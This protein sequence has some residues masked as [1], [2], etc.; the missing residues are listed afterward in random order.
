[1]WD[2]KQDSYNT[3]NAFPSSYQSN[4]QVWSMW[5]QAVFAN[6]KWAYYIPTWKWWVRI[7][8]KKSV[9][10][11]GIQEAVPQ[12]TQQTI[13]KDTTK[14]NPY[15]KDDLKMKKLV[16]LI[17][18]DPHTVSKESE[19]SIDRDVPWV[20]ANINPKLKKW[21]FGETAANAKKAVQA[22]WWDVNFKTNPELLIKAGFKI[23]KHWMIDAYWTK[24]PV[25]VFWNIWRWVVQ[26]TQPIIQE[27]IWNVKIPGFIRDVWNKIAYD[28]WTKMHT[29]RRVQTEND[30][31][32]AVDEKRNDIPAYKVWKDIAQWNFDNI[33][34]RMNELS[35]LAKAPLE[36]KPTVDPANPFAKSYF[37]NF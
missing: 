25:S 2:R 35:N 16:D 3:L 29:N 4:K 12:F 21:W 9:T 11:M 26:K 32:I 5:W 24:I 19:E 14:D 13:Q 1:M 20:D 36:R 8:N 27:K 30:P 34:T 6:S 15:L 37:L 23:D 18:S 17:S 22:W 31:M 28:L 33:A 7:V 10:P